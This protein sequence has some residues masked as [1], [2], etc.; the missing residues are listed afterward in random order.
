MHHLFRLNVILVIFFAGSIYS[1]P[2]DLSLQDLSLEDEAFIRKYSVPPSIGAILDGHVLEYTPK[3]YIWYQN[4]VGGHVHDEHLVWSFDELPGYLLK[5]PLS[6]IRGLE[7]MQECIEKH[8][9]DRLVVPKKY[10]YHVRGAKREL[11][12]ENY[13]VLAEK[14]EGKQPFQFDDEE[15]R[16]ICI[17]LRETGYRDFLAQNVLR[18]TNNKIAFI[19]T[20][21]SD[22]SQNKKYRSFAKIFIYLSDFSPDTSF[23]KAGLKH[24]LLQ[25]LACAPQEQSSY[26]HL[27]D[28]IYKF[29]KSH[30]DTM[31]WDY[32]SFFKETFPKPKPASS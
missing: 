3:Y 30:K 25:L 20:E 9:L 19:D 2:Q 24:I 6:R 17:L 5:Y 12:D 15:V 11:T 18:L 29:L 21:I 14:L 31:A 10:I 8:H 4:V 13:F 22:F 27:Y 7:I 23:S 28:T 32:V 1:E 16:Q 26:K